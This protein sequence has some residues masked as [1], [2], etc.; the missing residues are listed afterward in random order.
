[1][2][3]EKKVEFQSD[4]INCFKELPFYNTYIEKPKN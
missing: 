1:M 3:V 4:V 2:T